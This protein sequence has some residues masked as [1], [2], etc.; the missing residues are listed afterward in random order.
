MERIKAPRRAVGALFKSLSCHETLYAPTHNSFLQNGL[1]PV[2]AEASYAGRASF[3]SL[4]Y[5]EM[6]CEHRAIVCL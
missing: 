4:F 6:L 3:R 2:I 5:C 1:R